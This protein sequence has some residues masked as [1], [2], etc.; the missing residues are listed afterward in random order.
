VY[1][2]RYRASRAVIVR[3]EAE[4]TMAGALV[5]RGLHAWRERE[6]AGHDPAR[7]L[8]L[9]GAH[10]ANADVANADVADGR[11]RVSADSDGRKRV[12]LAG[13]AAA[14][15]GTMEALAA[16]AARP[17]LPVFVRPGEGMEPADLLTHPRVVVAGDAQRRLEGVDLVLAPAW[18]ETY[19]DEVAAA[20]ARGIPVVATQRAAGWLTPGPASEPAPGD[21]Q[22]LGMAIDR[23]LAAPGPP[24]L[25]PHVHDAHDRLVATLR[26]ALAAP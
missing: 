13:L 25:S 18:C 15:H 20:A 21:S 7:V 2:R 23:A 6:R 9:P 4:R 14:R 16:V 8:A 1:L 17:H 19:L 22:A 12:L 5:V 24:S 3:Q 26:A 11:P 10:V